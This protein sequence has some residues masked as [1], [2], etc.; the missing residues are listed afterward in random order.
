[1]CP[2]ETEGNQGSCAKQDG[3]RDIEEIQITMGLSLAERGEGK[4]RPFLSQAYL[5]NL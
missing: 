3:E 2:A 1:M 4:V 5:H